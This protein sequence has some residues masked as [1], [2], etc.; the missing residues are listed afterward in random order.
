MIARTI[1]QRRARTRPPYPLPAHL[2]PELARVHAYWGGLLRGGAQMPFWDDLRLTDLADL[3]GRL[4]LVDVFERPARFRINEVGSELS[5]AP[6]AGR[7]LDEVKL[8]APLEYLASQCS[9]TVECGAP[10]FF[11]AAAERAEIMAAPY[12][13]LLL[14]LWGD[15]RIGLLL[16][17]VEFG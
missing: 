2:T 10:T 13:R 11:R 12:G 17:A 15:G 6:V 1:I 4:L 16:G 3:A 5:T 14:P 8:E 9:A 7:F